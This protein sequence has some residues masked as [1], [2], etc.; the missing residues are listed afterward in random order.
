MHRARQR[1]ALR[2]STEAAIAR[3]DIRPPFFRKDAGPHN[4]PASRALS[5]LW[6]NAGMPEQAL[7]HVDLRGVD[8]VLPSSFAVGAAAQASVAAAALAAAEIGYL[9]RAGRQDV[10][11]DMTHAALECRNHFLLDGRVVDSRDKLTGMYRCGDGGWVRIHANFAHHRDG[12]LR[13]LGCAPGPQTQRADVERALQRWGAL[14]FEQA[15]AEAG[16]VVAA[17]RSF[18]H[19]DA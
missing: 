9:R 11:V 2:T 3:M 4:T 6:L 12:A 5:E 19:W 15:A 13:L 8:P 14:E 10:F 16:L 17:A 18:A 1:P 7:E